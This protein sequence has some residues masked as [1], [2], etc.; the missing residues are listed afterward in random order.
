MTSFETAHSHLKRPFIRKS[1]VKNKAWVPTVRTKFP[2]VGSKVPTAKPT[3]VAD[4]GNKGKDVKASACWIWKPKQNQG[5]N[6]NGVSENIDDKGYWDS[7]CS[8]HMTGN[9]SYLSE[10]EPYNGGYVSFRH[11]KGKITRFDY[12]HLMKES[13]EP[14]LLCPNSIVPT[15]T[16][17][18][19]KDKNKAKPDK[20]ESGIEK[21]A[22]NGGQRC[23][24][25]ENG[26]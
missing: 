4:K 14:H 25:I 18:S 19:L 8:R 11:G 26:A 9:I 17:Y 24:R 15:G 21:S 13:M 3:F 23:K 7:G 10:Y 2:T 6:L 20:T 12:E 5:S 1:A 22:K 16:G